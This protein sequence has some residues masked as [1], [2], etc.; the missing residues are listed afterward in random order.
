MP[1]S[2]VIVDDEPAM[3]DSLA[4]LLSVHGYEVAATQDPRKALEKIRR[5]RPDLLITDLKMPE[6]SGIHLLQSL[7]RD[8]MQIPTI[9]ISGYASV[10]NVVQAMQ[11]GARNFYEKPLNLPK[12]LQEI[13]RYARERPPEPRSYAELPALE[14][15]RSTTGNKQMQECL[16]HVRRAAP[17]DVPVVITGESGTGKELFAQAVHEESR[18]RGGPFVKINCAS[19]PE[20]LL[21]S[22]LFGHEKGAFTD[23][24]E[25]RPG[26]FEAAEGG[27]LF[28]D[29]IGEMSM[30]M[31]AKLLRAIQEKEYERVGSNRTRSMDIRFIAATNRDLA[32]SVGSGAFREDLYYRLSVVH[33]AVPPLRLRGD[34]VISIAERLSG[35]LSAK[36]G[37]T[38]PRLSREAERFFRVHPWPGNVR[39]LRNCIERAIIFTDGPELTME[40]MPEQYRREMEPGAFC[41]DFPEAGN[42]KGVYDNVCKDLILETLEKTGFSRG[43]TAE[44]LG[45]NR[46]TLYNKMK[47]LGLE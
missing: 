37:K 28:F 41:E 15:I 1:F 43:R 31:Q 16:E 42:L 32:A 26:K 22:E 4:R 33:I 20:P 39:E 3:C 34:D 11:F 44:L 13:E 18:R 5:R 7:H 27:T 45:I 17:T 10:E 47:R 19:I 38:A 25:A 9:M 30:K 6:I 21:E 24:A 14:R 8:R 46:R 23:A 12:L 36:Y 29:E 2:I 40:T 35:E